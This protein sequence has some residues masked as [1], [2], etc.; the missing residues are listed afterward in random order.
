MVSNSKEISA[1]FRADKAK[2]N[3]GQQKNDKVCS[4]AK[5]RVTALSAFED[6]NMLKGLGLL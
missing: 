2:F 4:I 3:A 6:R 5:K 1:Q